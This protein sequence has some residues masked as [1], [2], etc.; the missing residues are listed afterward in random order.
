MQPG[1][2]SSATGSPF[3]RTSLTDREVA[4]RQ[5]MLEHLNGGAVDA[6]GGAPSD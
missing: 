3:R 4:H 1:T 5:R 2:A 6:S